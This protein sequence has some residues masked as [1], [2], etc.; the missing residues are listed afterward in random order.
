V[1]ESFL[2]RIEDPVNK[3]STPLNIINDPAF[4][5]LLVL[6]IN[7]FIVNNEAREHLSTQIKKF[8]KDLKEITQDCKGRIVKDQLNTALIS[9]RSVSSA[10]ACAKQLQSNFEPNPFLAKWTVTED[11]YIYMHWA[12]TQI[13]SYEGLMAYSEKAKV[14]QKAINELIILEKLNFYQAK[15]DEYA[16]DYLRR[17]NQLLKKRGLVVLIY[18]YHFDYIVCKIEDKDKVVELLDRLKLEFIAP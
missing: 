2:G 1:V 7:Y 3:N 9:F 8:H 10:I 5:V 14:A 13:M 15:P 4:R 17:N 11:E 16:Y 18:N 6:R 12:I